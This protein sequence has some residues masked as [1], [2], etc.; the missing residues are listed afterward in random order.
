VNSVGADK[1]VAGRGSPI[2]QRDGDAVVILIEALD[3]RTEM[4]T[5]CSKTAK[6]D[7]EQVGAVRGVIRRT[8][9]CFRPLA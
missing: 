2:R 4:K 6:Q 5:F 3:A 7:I 1:D 8:E 9:M